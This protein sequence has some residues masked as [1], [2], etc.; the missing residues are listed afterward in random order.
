MKKEFFAEVKQH[1]ERFYDA[2]L[3]DDQFIILSGRQTEVR[4]KV[5]KGRLRFEQEI[6]GSS[7]LVSSGGISINTLENFLNRFWYRE[8][9]ETI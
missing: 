6:E 2:S 1:L 9:Q 5:L 4:M 8:K 7:Y 3:S